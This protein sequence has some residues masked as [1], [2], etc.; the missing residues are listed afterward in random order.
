VHGRVGIDEA[1]IVGRQ[2]IVA[3]V[4]RDEVVEL[5]LRLGKQDANTVEKPVDLTFAAEKNTP[6][7]QPTAV[8][9]M[10]LGVG[11][12]QGR[13]PRTAED[14]PG[15]DA[16]FASQRFHVGDQMR[17]GVVGQLAMRRGAAAAA[18]VEQN[19]AV[20][21][22]IEEPPLHRRGA[23]AGPAVHEQHRDAIRVAGRFPVDAMATCRFQHAAGIGGDERVER[24]NVGHD[25]RLE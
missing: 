4:L 16:E 23:G 9:G 7:H 17:R 14:Q 12:R 3:F 15:V 8:H 19:D 21:C 11:E 10:R 13:A 24:S 6:Q 22:R 25:G 2:Q 18:L 20:A 5:A 1:A